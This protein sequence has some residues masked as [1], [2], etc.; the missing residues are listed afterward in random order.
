[1]A[2]AIPVGLNPVQDFVIQ[3][4]VGA[5][6]FTVVLM[7]AVALAWLVH[8]IEGWGFAPQWLIGGAHVIEFSLSW[9]DSLSFGLFL[10]AEVAKLGRG[11]WREWNRG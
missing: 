2:I 5:F 6:L 11:L 7:V 10:M 9:V 8:C 4:V 3:V 1:M